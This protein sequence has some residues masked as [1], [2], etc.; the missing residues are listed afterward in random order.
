[1]NVACL[2]VC[3][4]NINVKINRTIILPVILYGCE[5]WLLM[6]WEKSSLRVYRNRV[7][8]RIFGPQRDELIGEWRRLHNELNDLYSPTVI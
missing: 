3:Y 6:W 5:T 2:P 7:Q 4:K 8:R 1:M